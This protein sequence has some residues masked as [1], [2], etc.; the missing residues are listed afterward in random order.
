[1]N[2][3]LEEVVGENFLKPIVDVRHSDLEDVS[4]DSEYKKECPVCGQGMLVCSRDQ[5]TMELKEID[6]CVVCAQ[7][8]RYLDIDEMRKNDWVDYNP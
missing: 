7:R 1:M 6:R 5:M 8:F 4:E 3:E 2:G